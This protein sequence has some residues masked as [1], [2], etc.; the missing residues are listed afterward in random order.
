MLPYLGTSS[1]ISIHVRP[2]AEWE[3]VASFPH[4]ATECRPLVLAGKVD[5]LP[6][7]KLA[8]INR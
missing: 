4:V 2:R 6:L 1:S 7:Q 3:A 5:G 8:I